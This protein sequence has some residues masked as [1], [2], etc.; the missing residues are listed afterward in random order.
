MVTVQEDR[1]QEVWERKWGAGK[2]KAHVCQVDTQRR[3]PRAQG[4]REHV[5][6]VR[7]YWS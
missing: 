6:A 4:Y 1:N 7:R 3:K 2:E 5:I